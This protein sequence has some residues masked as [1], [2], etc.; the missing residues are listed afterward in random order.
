MEQSEFN[1]LMRRYSERLYHLIRNIVH[2]HEDTMDILQDVWVKVWK[3]IG[4]FRE[5]S[6]IFTWL[7]R[8]AVNEAIS[9]LR[10]RK[11]KSFVTFVDFDR[12]M[13]A[14]I[15]DGVHFNGDRLEK[16]L[17]KA[18]AT[19]PPKQKAV[20]AL[21][22]FE[23]MPYGQMAEVLGSSAASLKVSYSIACARVKEILKREID[24]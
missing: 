4:S 6:E 12:R 2:S 11:V 7:Y 21:R 17:L 13:A 10:K 16:D 19:L 20:F 15:E 24:F 23:E 8:I 14:E 18:M 9:F 1:L 22:Y 5:E 3:S